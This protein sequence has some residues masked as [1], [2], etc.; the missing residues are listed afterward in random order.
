MSNFLDMSVGEPTRTLI[1]KS[2]DKETI[3]FE[4]DDKSTD[5]LQFVVHDKET[6]KDFKISDTW[7]KAPDG[8]F[9]IKGLWLTFTK[10]KEGQEQISP[11]GT[12]AKLLEF[13]KVSNLS[14][15][16]GKEITVY[17]DPKNYLVLTTCEM[18][19]AS[20]P[21]KPLFS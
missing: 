3:Y 7:V 9:S 16:I 13:Y 4:K 2:I 10:D 6:D 1:V 20:D 8:T 5:K 21:E 18:P 14:E 12:V 11:R 15:L 17:P 19:K